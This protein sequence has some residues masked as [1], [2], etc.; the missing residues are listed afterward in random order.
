MNKQS[1]LVVDYLSEPGHIN[2][3]R[4]FLGHISKYWQTYFLCEEKYQKD[5]DDISPLR[6][7]NFSKSVTR[8]QTHS[9]FYYFGKLKQIHELNKI[10]QILKPTFVL[11]ICYEPISLQY[12]RYSFGEVFLFEHNNIDIIRKD[13]KRRLLFRFIPER[14][15]HISYEKYISN[16]IK[17]HFRKRNTEIPHP[18]YAIGRQQTFPLDEIRSTNREVIFAPSGSAANI[19]L[20]ELISYAKEQNEFHFVLKG[21]L[22]VENDDY[23]IKPFY[24]SYAKI[25]SNSAYILSTV[26]FEYRVSGIIYEALAMGKTVV[27]LDTKLH[28]EIKGQYPNMVH[29]INSVEELRGLSKLLKKRNKSNILADQKR[30]YDDHSNE[31]IALALKSIFR[32]P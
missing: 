32:R 13:W 9:M 3:N 15:V 12:F 28:R 7:L 6:I 16:F 14:F 19:V 25:M 21:E 2:S 20:N 4:Y 1:I 31:T 26:D 24:K 17:V 11:F 23:T 18:Y 22:A 27:G 8:R 5:F 10:V 29:I 30:F